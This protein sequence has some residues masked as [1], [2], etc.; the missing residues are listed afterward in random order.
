VRERL[1]AGE[2]VGASLSGGIDSS[3]VV[4]LAAR[5]HD[6]QVHTYSVS[7]GAEYPNELEFS[8]I[9]AAH[10]GTRHHVVE[11]SPDAVARN[12]DATIALL[13][14][15]IGD[16]L[17]VPNALL[18]AAAAADARVILNGEGGDPC[19]GGPKNVPMVLA[20]LFG[21]LYAGDARRHRAASYL[22]AHQKCYDD[23]GEMLAPEALAEIP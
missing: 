16:P 6:A 14:D 13:G 4:A 3:L 22:R 23:L 9:V 1:P 19:F 10:C 15:P 5:L 8:S 17:T 21:D 7:F 2:P 18:F 12:L 20:E 11:I